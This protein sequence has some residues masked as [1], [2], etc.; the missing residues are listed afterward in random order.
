MNIS[1]PL[2]NSTHFN[3][4]PCYEAITPADITPAIAFLLDQCK[5]A[6]TQIEQDQSAA[7]WDNTVTPLEKATEQLDRAWGLVDHLHSVCDTPELRAAYNDN[8]PIVTDFFTALGQNLTLF[9]KYRAIQHSPEFANYS[10]GKKRVIHNALRDF[11]LSGAELSDEKKQRFAALQE[12]LAQLS[13][14]YSEHVLDATNDYVLHIEDLDQ[15]SGLP[16]DALA[17]A[18]LKAQQ[19]GKPGYVFG[20]QF[21][22]YYPILQYADNR[23]LRAAIYRANSTKASELGANPAWDNSAVMN[24]IVAL[25]AEKARLLGYDNYAQVSLASKMADSPEQVTQFL[26]D[27]A[28][29]AR[30]YAK[31]DWE[32]LRQFAKQSLN[33]DD[34]QAH[35]IAYASE[36]L[37]EQRY[38]FSDQEVKQY[39]PE[40]QVIQGLF[41]IAHTLYGI[42]IQPDQAQGWHPDVKFYRIEKQ[43]QLIGQFYLDLY[44]RQNKNG[45]AWMN[46][47]KSRWRTE[48]GLQTPLAYLI[49]N[50]SEP[51]PGKPAYFTHDEVIT[52][53]HEFGHGLHHLLTEVDDLAVSGLSGVEWDAVELPSQFME[54]FCWE[55]EVLQQM[56]AHCDTGQPLPRSLYDNMLAAKNFQSGLQTLR[57]IEFALFDMRLHDGYREQHQLSIQA[58]LNQVRAQIAVLPISE[59][60]RFQHAFSHIFAGGYAAGYFSYKW[61]EVLSADTY[62]AFEEAGNKEETGLKFLRE[63]LA[64]GGSRP[65]MNSFIAFRGRPPKIDALLRHSGM[66]AF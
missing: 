66:T 35:D 17:A 12:Q 21:P 37:R 6:I 11:T 2:I 34:L 48:Q 51:L 9:K 57:Q 19:L 56:S 18:Q 41:Q 54:N 63:I 1:N 8:Q 10:D 14:T 31:R 30:P 55:W 62:A 20:L 32:E 23:Q 39:F 46:H 28:E 47:A 33:L 64:V 3:S 15:L 22:S 53:F 52:L 24:Q 36:K 38:A 50:F 13:N 4:L 7:T 42:T 43:G 58:V 49:G 27:L 59:F 65:A 60:N 40:T 61:A 26:L 5:T 44:A 45:G 16:K 29:R 25:R